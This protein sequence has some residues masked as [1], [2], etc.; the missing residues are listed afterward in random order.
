VASRRQ[1]VKGKA[2]RPR[3]DW[4]D[5]KMPALRDYVEYDALGN[6]VGSGVEVV[7]PKVVTEVARE[8][9]TESTE[10]S[11]ND[12]PSYHWGHDRKRRRL[13]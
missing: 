11:W 4:R 8:D 2:E 6:I 12:D 5:P 10:P 7:E 3:L 13:R 1:R 9:L